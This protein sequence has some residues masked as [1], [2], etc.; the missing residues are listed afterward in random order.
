MTTEMCTLGNQLDDFRRGLMMARQSGITATYN[1][2]NDEE[3]KDADIVE[4]REIHRA[5]DEAVFRAYGWDDLIPKLDY[6][7]HPV[8]RDARFTV[9]PGVQQEIVD[10]LLELNQERYAAEVSAG[11]HN[12]KTKKKASVPRKPSADDGQETFF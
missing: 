11:L 10:R 9:G 3:C 8:G 4:L 12:K 5:I 6:G 7:I 2:V 1:L